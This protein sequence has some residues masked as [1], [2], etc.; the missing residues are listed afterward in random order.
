MLGGLVGQNNLK[1]SSLIYEPN[2]DNKKIFR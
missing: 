1:I 2:I